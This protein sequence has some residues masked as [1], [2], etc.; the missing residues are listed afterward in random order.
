MADIPRCYFDLCALNRPFDDFSQPRV[1]HESEAMLKLVRAVRER[2]IELVTSE[3]IRLE[4]GANPFPERKQWVD[5][6]LA[7]ASLDQL[8]DEVSADRASDL[9]RIG[10][11]PAD[12]LHLAFAER[13]VVEVFVTCDDRVVRRY[14]GSMTVI[15]P[16][17][18][19]ERLGIE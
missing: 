10:L 6:V 11:D 4:N 14:T 1:V 19:V 3:I 17:G 13:S 12:A 9:Q 15:G 2:R 7:L 5:E 8:A 18:A 16:I